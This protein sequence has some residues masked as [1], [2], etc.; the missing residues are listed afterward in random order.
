VASDAS[1]AAVATAAVGSS[2]SA[3]QQQQAPPLLGMQIVPL[4]G[5]LSAEVST[6]YII[7][8]ERLDTQASVLISVLHIAVVLLLT[9]MLCA[10]VS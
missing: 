5:A 8:I 2:S 3:Q 4:Y 6:P 7:V 1:A 9:N 10:H